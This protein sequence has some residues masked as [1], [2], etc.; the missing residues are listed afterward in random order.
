MKIILADIYH[1]AH[2][3]GIKISP[4]KKGS[5][6]FSLRLDLKYEDRVASICFR[7][8]MNYTSP[9]SMDK[10][11]KSWTGKE[12]KLIFPYTK[13]SSIEAVR[14]DQEF[15]PIEDFYNEIK[16]VIYVTHFY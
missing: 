1:Y 4:V 7:D 2:Q 16:Q 10:Y 9:M 15:P 5:K 13:Y 14:S 3:R 8:I 12:S 6:Y 11:V